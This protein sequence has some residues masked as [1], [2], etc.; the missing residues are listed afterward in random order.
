MASPTLN[1]GPQRIGWAPPT[2]EGTCTVCSTVPRE[3]LTIARHGKPVAR[4]VSE[5][6]DRDRAQEAAAH[7][8]ER[9]K[10]LARVPL[11]DLM[12]TIREGHEY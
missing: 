10:H 3:S 12:A 8:I 4:L 1:R 2:P 5:T 7:I 6:S 9:C 11:D